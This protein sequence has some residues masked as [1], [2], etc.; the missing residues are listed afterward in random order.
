METPKRFSRIYIEIS[1]ICNLQCSFCPVVEREK[2][3]M[4]VDRFRSILK[5]AAPLAEQICL[6]V[7]GEPLGHPE[8]PRFVQIAEE[9][10]VLLQ[11][12][13]NGT[14]LDEKRS[15]ALLRPSIRQ[16]NFSLQSFSDNFP[17]SDPKPY[18]KKI[19]VFAKQAELARPDLYINFR[20]WNLGDDQENR[21]TVF[22][23]FLEEELEI[24]ISR[25]V[26]PALQKSKKLRNRLYLHFDSRFEWPTEND[27]VHKS[28]L[29]F[30]HALSNQIAILSD[31]SVVPCCLDKEAKLKLGN[32]EETPLVEILEGARA[33]HIR[34]GFARGQAVEKLCQNCDYSKRFQKKALRLAKSL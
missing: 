8:F 3:V 34:E 22:L 4:P 19:L 2:D 14:L 24:K 30:C 31:G 9:Q 32:C 6:H 21:N 26:D 17:K 15:A 27:H 20:L 7:M 16:V 28:E 12:T 10:E 5:E 33:R 18:W 1:N 25:I 23:D 29:G 11:I 13:T